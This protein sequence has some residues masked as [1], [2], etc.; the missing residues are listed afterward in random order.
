MMLEHVGRSGPTGVLQA[1]LANLCSMSAVK[2]SHY[3]RLLG[4]RRL[5]AR[6][7]VVLTTRKTGGANVTFTAVIVLARFACVLDQSHGGKRTTGE[8]EAPAQL[9]DG[10]Y[11][12]HPQ[13]GDVKGLTIHSLNVEMGAKRILDALKTNGVM[14]QRDLKIIA[15]PD[16]EKPPAFSDLLFTR[17]RHRMFRAFRVRLIKAGMVEAVERECVDKDGKV[18]GVLKCLKLT[19]EI[20]AQGRVVVKEEGQGLGMVAEEEDD[21]AEGEGAKVIALGDVGE[22]AEEGTEDCNPLNGS[23][24][25][26][27]GK[28]WGKKIGS[29]VAEV[30]L[31]EQVYRLLREA[32]PK[33][34]S[35]PELYSHLDGGCDLTSA[36]AKRIRNIVTGIS[37]FAPIVETQCFEGSIMVLRIVLAEFSD[38]NGVMQTPKKTAVAKLTQLGVESVSVRNHRKS[39]LARKK[40]EMTTLGLQRQEMVMKLLE[41]KKAIVME[42]LGR[43]VAELEGAGLHRVDQKV[44]KRVINSLVLQKRATVLTT[45]KPTVTETKQLQTI[46]MVVL[47]GLTHQSPEVASAISSIVTSALYGKAKPAQNTPHKRKAEQVA[48]NLAKA[49]LGDSESTAKC[50]AKAGSKAKKNRSTKRRRSIPEKVSTDKNC[51][52]EAPSCG[53]V[54]DAHTQTTGEDTHL[55]DEALE[56]KSTLVNSK[57]PDKEPP[58]DERVVK[59]DAVLV[60]NSKRDTRA[61]RISRLV[62][63]DHGWMKGKMTRVKAL[64]E[65]LYKISTPNLPITSTGSDSTTLQHSTIERAKST[66]NIGS[67]TISAC[68]QEMTVSMYASI[69]GIYSDPGE[70]IEAVYDR[71]VREVP[72]I[73]DTELKCKSAERQICSLVQVLVKLNLLVLAEEATFLLSGAGVLRDFGRGVPPGLFPHGIIFSSQDAVNVYWKELFQYAQ[74]HQFGVASGDNGERLPKEGQLVDRWS[75]PVPDVYA[76]ASWNKSLTH[77]F[78]LTEQLNLEATLQSMSGVTVFRDSKGRYLTSSFVTTTL[79]RFAVS[80]IVDEAIKATANAKTLGNVERSFLALERLLMYS[81]Y[82]TRHPMPPALC[83]ETVIG[84][85]SNVEATAPSTSRPRLRTV[86]R[87]VRGKCNVQPTIEIRGLPKVLFSSPKESTVSEKGQ[88]LIIE[89]PAS[90]ETPRQVRV[91]VDLN[92]CV[93]LLRIVVHSRALKHCENTG[94]VPDWNVTD[95]LVDNDKTLEKGVTSQQKTKRKHRPK[96]HPKDKK[97]PENSMYQR[98]ASDLCSQVSTQGVLECLSLKLAFRLSVAFQK[99]PVQSMGDL[100]SKLQADWESLNNV[101]VAAVLRAEYDLYRNCRVVFKMADQSNLHFGKKHEHAIEA[102]F[103]LRINSR[104]SM[105]QTWTQRMQLLAERYRLVVEITVS[106]SLC[107]GFVFQEESMEE[108][109]M[110]PSDED[111]TPVRTEVME[112]ILIS[113]VNEGRRTQKSSKVVSLLRGFRLQDIVEA[114]NRLLLRE[115]ITV[116]RNV[117]GSRYFQICT[118]DRGEARSVSLKRVRECEEVWT[119]KLEEETIAGIKRF[120]RTTLG[121]Q[122]FSRSSES[123][124]MLGAMTSVRLIFCARERR[125]EMKPV[126]GKTGDG[127]LS[128][129]VDLGAMEEWDKKEDKD[130]EEGFTMLDVE[131]KYDG[132]KAESDRIELR[133]EIGEHNNLNGLNEASDMTNELEKELEILICSRGYVGITLEELEQSGVSQAQSDTKKVCEAVEHM[134]QADVIGR[135]VIEGGNVEWHSGRNVLFVADKHLKGI[136][137]TSVWTDISGNVTGFLG[138]VA[139]K[140]VNIVSQKPGIEAGEIVKYIQMRFGGIC[141]R[142]VGD[143]IYELGGCGVLRVERVLRD[144]GGVFGSDTMDVGGGWIEAGVD[145]VGEGEWFVSCRGDGLNKWR[146]EGIKMMRIR[147]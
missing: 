50:N 24:S 122:T 38:M 121:Q 30:D 104:M 5:V 144:G 1:E 34:M 56:K 118:K 48:S 116:C 22:E 8:V 120:R 17:R 40:D 131:F 37:R 44:M 142:D 138:D 66:P 31:L 15:L 16:E 96:N 25:L 59:E 69:V 36:P 70:Q 80:E 47:P 84:N 65:Q 136:G 133:E 46:R 106:E 33:G 12:C 125:L 95:L 132:Q 101:L 140:I 130:R 85:N 103:N 79:K 108:L 68:L 146:T 71:R 20:E 73:M 90:G 28:G 112:R 143:V 9:D 11:P 52:R 87:L 19:G 139:S 60:K 35:V 42:T 7:K 2:V 54:E 111:L 74:F 145:R 83:E 32:G 49:E 75:Y 88:A 91:E 109:M 14:T 99:V 43:Q 21:D 63:I 23:V 137:G 6:R 124:S 39:E 135:I 64:H 86:L 53:L 82:R 100:C 18:K 76:R 123:E 94:V 77:T 105:D 114:R 117:D 72:E 10:S 3:T 51:S 98:I 45:V 92:R 55:R 113:V 97:N 61:P 29:F 13:V 102:E 78:M 127:G 26:S 89:Q 147:Q 81:R 119:G 93:S 141:Q 27:G 128:I 110:R 4:E 67:F 62:A 57:V 129:G 107:Y 58:F 126:I 41:E 134:V 115:A